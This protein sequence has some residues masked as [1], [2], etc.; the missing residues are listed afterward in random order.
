[1]H[2][3]ALLLAAHTCVATKTCPNVIDY[4]TVTGYFLQ[5]DAGTDPSTF[6]YVGIGRLYVYAPRS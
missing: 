6:N 1:M 3:A 5:D 2:A 4:S